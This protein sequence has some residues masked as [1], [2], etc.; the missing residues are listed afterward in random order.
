MN[1]TKQEDEDNPALAA[2]AKYK[3]TIG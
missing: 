3:K 1:M 2:I